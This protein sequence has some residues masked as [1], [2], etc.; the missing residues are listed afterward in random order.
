MTQRDI[1]YDEGI[2]NFKKTIPIKNQYYTVLLCLC[3]S[4][5]IKVGFHH[6]ELQAETIAII[7]PNT[8]FSTDHSSSDLAVKQIYFHKNFLQKL[9]FKEEIIEEL[10]L[11]NS[12]YPPFYELFS[13]FQFV[14]DRFIAIAREIESQQAY[15]LDVIRLILLEILYEYNRACEYCLLGFEKNMNRN[16]QVTYAFKKLVEE[17]FSTWKSLGIYASHLSISAKHLTEVVKEETGYTAL[18]LIHDRLLLES[19]YLLKHTPHSIKECAAILGF[20][21][22]SYFSRFFKSHLHMAPLDFRKRPE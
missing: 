19:Q 15:H 1:Q 16:Y 3:G 9:F 14:E 5:A 12:N 8:L 4:A 2:E 21:S 10:L 7:P 6:F 18:Q 20:D 13:R 22:A 17:H 11:L